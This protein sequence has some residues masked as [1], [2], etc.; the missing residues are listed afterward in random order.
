MFMQFECLRVMY[1]AKYEKSGSDTSYSELF[2]RVLPKGVEP[3]TFRTLVGC[4]FTELHI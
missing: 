4:S 1:S 3:M 2:F